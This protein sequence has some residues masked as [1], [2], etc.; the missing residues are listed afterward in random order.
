MA[1]F[2]QITVHLYYLFR[3]QRRCGSA[4]SVKQISVVQKRYPFPGS[5]IHCRYVTGI[6]KTP[7]RLE[8]SQ[9]CNILEYARVC[10]AH[11]QEHVSLKP[12]KYGENHGKDIR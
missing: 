10:L 4:Q 9:M 1:V 8:L 2:S 12:S 3:E 7:V 11:S 6:F 5:N